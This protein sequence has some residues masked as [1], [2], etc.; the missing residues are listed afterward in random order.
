M[1]TVTFVTSNDVKFGSAQHVAEQLGYTLKRAQIDF[2]E[3]Q[4]D[5]QTIA[6]HKAE[7]AYEELKQPVIIT[8][9]SWNIPGLNGFP[10]SYMK[11]VNGW[12]TPEDWL[13]LTLPLTNRRIILSQH[14]IYQDEHGQHYFVDE[15]TG[16]L[17]KDIRGNPQFPFL[18]ITSLDDGAHSRAE[19]LAAGEPLLAG[20]T[21]TVWHQLGEWLRQAEN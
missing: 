21:N 2:Q 1:K 12:L 10:G 8:D 7:Q 18:T 14:A 4:A 13:R 11:Q 20:K 3:I 6:R 15:V 19:T 16:L 9:D 17:L 5:A